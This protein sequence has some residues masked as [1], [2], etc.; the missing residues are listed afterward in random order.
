MPNQK[1]DLLI[2]IITG[3]SA[4]E[5]LDL[6][7]ETDYN[8]LFLN[9]TKMQYCLK[10]FKKCCIVVLKIYFYPNCKSWDDVL[11]IFLIFY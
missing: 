3:N 8:L 7:I 4:V 10:S 2:L 6:F 5:N 1:N 9:N 11:V